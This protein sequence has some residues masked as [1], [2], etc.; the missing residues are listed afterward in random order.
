MLLYLHRRQLKTPFLIVPKINMRNGRARKILTKIHILERIEQIVYV[1]ILFRENILHSSNHRGI[2]RQ[3]HN[4]SN[5]SAIFD[6]CYIW[7]LL[8]RKVNIFNKAG[9]PIDG[10][11][12]FSFSQVLL[13]NI[14]TA[15]ITYLA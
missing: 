8:M 14:R 6:N 3:L 12:S 13:S 2:G 1:D 10:I 11:L 5:A 15:L 4:T 9:S 7:P